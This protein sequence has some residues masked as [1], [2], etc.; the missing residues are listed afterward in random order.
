MSNFYN[1]D[2]IK[3]EITKRLEEE[4]AYLNAWKAVTF[5]TKKDGTPFAMLSKNIN[6]AKF[7][8]ESYAMQDGE[9]ELTVYAR[10]GA[11]S[12]TDTIKCYELVKYLKDPEQIE[13][14]QNYAA[15][16]CP[17]LEQVYVFDLDDVKKAVSKRIAYLE[18][19]IKKLTAQ[20]EQTDKVYHEFYSAYGEAMNKLE[21]ITKQFD[22][23]TLF[24][25]VRDT[26]KERYPYGA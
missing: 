13:K 22:D 16:T 7:A 3:T 2:G 25:L 10:A 24:Y 12:I 26:V 23:N 1:A 9:N 19:H 14:K 6:G 11:R 18:E 21:E 20:V 4:R 15:Q 8:K 17:W 5:P